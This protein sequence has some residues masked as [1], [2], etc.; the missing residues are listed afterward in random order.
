[1][2][3]REREKERWGVIYELFEQKLS[4]E[5]KHIT[6]LK[7]IISPYADRLEYV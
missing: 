2:K 3:E 7:L 1:M 5:M 6:R 4:M